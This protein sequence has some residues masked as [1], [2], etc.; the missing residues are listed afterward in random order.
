MSP[1]AVCIACTRKRRTEWAR[2]NRDPEADRMA[3]HKWRRNN[4]EEYAESWRRYNIKRQQAW[5]ENPKLAEEYR[6]MRRMEYRLRREREGATLQIV[7]GVISREGPEVP[8]AP[9]FKAIERLMAREGIEVNGGQWESDYEGFCDR[10]GIS[11][12]TMRDLRAGRRKVLRLSTVER[13]LTN[14]AWHWW[15][16]WDPGDEGYELVERLFEGEQVAA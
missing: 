11:D 14:T 4:P 6:A 3:T 8:A 12:R 2:E 1:R 13:V 10:I 9:L 5:A 7:D 15:D 16:V